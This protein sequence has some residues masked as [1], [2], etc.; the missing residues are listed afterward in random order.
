MDGFMER[1]MNPPPAPPN[2]DVTPPNSPPGTDAPHFAS[3][4]LR[5]KP[6]DGH[7]ITVGCVPAGVMDAK[8]ADPATKMAARARAVAAVAAIERAPR[9]TR[10]TPTPRTPATPPGA[11]GE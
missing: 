1:E 3:T 2:Y 9:S 10:K 4:T 11:R 7:I 5:P 8:P 6:G